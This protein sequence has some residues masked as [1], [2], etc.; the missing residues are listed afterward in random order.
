MNLY[1][2][3]VKNNEKLRHKML[4]QYKETEI[5]KVYITTTKA[6]LT[7]IYEYNC[8]NFI[9]CPDSNK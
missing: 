8:E 7:L 1:C 2:W 4:L 6:L 9:F 3:L 5:C